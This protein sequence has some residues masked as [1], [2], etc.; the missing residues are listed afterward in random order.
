MAIANYLTMAVRVLQVRVRV[1]P[2]GDFGFNCL[3]QQSLSAVTENVGQHVA[4]LAA[5]ND[6]VE[7]ILSAMVAY[8]GGIGSLS[9]QIQTQVRRLFQLSRPQHSTRRQKGG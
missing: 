2:L 9:N 8:S 5:G 7:L 6:N 3:S 1:D 4:E